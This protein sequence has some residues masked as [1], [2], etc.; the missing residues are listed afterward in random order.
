MRDRKRGRSADRGGQGSNTLSST[1][2]G[3]QLRLASPHGHDSKEIG[4]LRG[5]QGSNTLSSTLRGKQLRLAS[6]Q[7][8]LGDAHGANE[9]DSEG[10]GIHGGG[11]R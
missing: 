5:G 2:G 10:I 6:P 7:V 3:K 4:V 1:L 9:S 8:A 11:Q